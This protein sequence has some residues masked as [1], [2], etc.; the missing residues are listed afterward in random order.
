MKRL[1]VAST[2]RSAGKTSLIAGIAKASG[3]DFGYM[4]P[5]GDRLLYRKKRLWDYDCALMTNIFG[6]S[7]DVEDMTIGF[8]RSKLMYMY[9]EAGTNERLSEMASRNEEGKELLF[10]ECGRDLAYGTSVFLDAISVV[11]SLGG[12]LVLVADEDGNSSVDSVAFIRKYVDMSGVRFEGVVVNKVRNLEDYKETNLAEM[13]R[14]GIDV[15]GVVPYE[16]EMTHVSVGLLA[17]RLLARV[18]AGEGGLTRRARNILV[19][20]MSTNA[21]I[22]S[23]LFQRED[24][25][26]IT[27]GDRS[28]MIVAA[29]KSDTA[30]VILTNN[31][32]PSPNI[33][34]QASQRNIPLLLVPFDT[35]ETA[36]HID[37]IE[38]LLT[39]DDSD[40]LE[41]CSRLVR[42]HV[43]L[44]KIVP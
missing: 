11:R 4:K 28:D 31:I 40:K 17:E 18:V 36:M 19:G 43:N 6:L 15:L 10:V 26:I 22:Q 8:E 41:L 34:S 44:D 12:S 33:V 9:D 25:L 14:R 23:P 20:A 29:L 1:V 30:G 21:A 16:P 39:K 42:E 35:Y 24:K 32:L 7:E 37:T 38:P 27:A 2:H 13:S 3:K 5:M